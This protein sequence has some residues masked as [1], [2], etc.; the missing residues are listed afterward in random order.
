MSGWEV[1]AFCRECDYRLEKP[2]FGNIWFTERSFPICP[3][4]GEYHN[5]ETVRIKTNWQGKELERK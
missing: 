1:W 5:Y 4:C 2:S 3:N